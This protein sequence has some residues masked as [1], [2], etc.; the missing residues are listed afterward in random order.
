[1]TASWPATRLKDLIDHVLR[2]TG[3]SQAQLAALAPM[4]QSA[5]SKWRTG[6]T[7]PKYESL[8]AMGR[9]LQERFPGP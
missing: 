9:A 5:L 8:Q 1:M 7:K 3:L 4:D 2:E 6:S